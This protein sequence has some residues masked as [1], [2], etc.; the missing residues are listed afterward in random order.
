MGFTEDWYS[1]EQA[2]FLSQLARST[3]PLSGLIIEI[4]SWEG[5]STVALANAVYPEMVLAVDTWAGNY[6]EAPDH[7]TV[8]LAKERDIY[9]AFLENVRTLTKGNVTPFKQDCHEFLRE[10]SEPV[11][12]CH[13]DASHDYQSVRRTIEAVLPLLVRGG[14]L[15]GDDFLTSNKSREDLGG[16]VERAVVELLHGFGNSG[17]LWYWQKP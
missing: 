12:F 15:C 17:N 13:I 8:L 3:L 9:A 11:R 5:K 7:A 2:A 4:G 16:G 1:D 14:T 10:L 6:D